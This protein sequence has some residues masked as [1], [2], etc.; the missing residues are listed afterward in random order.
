[1]HN[2]YSPELTASGITPVAVLAALPVLTLSPSSMAERID[3]FGWSAT[4]LG[5][6]HAWPN[7][8][9]II[10]RQIL[11]SSFP[12]A[13]VW[14]DDLTT[15]YNDAFVPISA[16]SPMRSAVRGPI[17]G[18]RRGTRSGVTQS[19]RSQARTPISRIFR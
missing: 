19:G 3:A 12:K 1:M 15:I 14:G 4:P 10:V 9:A 11:D 8:L 7:E 17:S 13:I 6:R 18:R 16:R 2:D 5:P